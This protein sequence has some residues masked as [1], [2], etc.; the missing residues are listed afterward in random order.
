[1]NFEQMADDAEPAL[2]LLNQAL[3]LALLLTPLVKIF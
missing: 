3:A 2:T 1:V